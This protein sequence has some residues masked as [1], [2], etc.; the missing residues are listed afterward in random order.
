MSR[1]P[2]L[3]KVMR[4]ILID[5]LVD[6]HRKFLLAPETLYLTVNIIDRYLS[7]VQVARSRLQLVGVT[8]LLIASKY[9]EIYPPLVRDCVYITNRAY[10]RQQVLDMEADILEQLDFRISKPTA[11][12]FLLRFLD[13]TGANDLMSVAAE[14]YTER[15]F[16]EISSLNVRPSL[17]AAASVCLAIN[18]DSFRDGTDDELPGIVRSWWG[19]FSHT[20]V[21]SRLILSH[22]Q[23]LLQPDSLL[24]YTGFTRKSILETAQVIVRKVEEETITS[25]KRALVSVKRKFGDK[26]R[27]YISEDFPTPDASMLESS[28]P[29]SD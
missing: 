7:L 27:R 5:W 20:F 29:F 6:V 11:Y 23:F 16:Q 15:M 26:E 28:G 8:A 4:A 19:G 22:T 13:I 24:A 25:N 17:L 10:T 14:Y 12:P 2:E 21:C 18:Q 3:N 9:E 1:Q